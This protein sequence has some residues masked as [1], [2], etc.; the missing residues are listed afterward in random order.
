M[1]RVQWEGKTHRGNCAMILRQI[2]GIIY[3]DDPPESSRVGI[4]CGSQCVW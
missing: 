3:P 2:H 4:P 1:M